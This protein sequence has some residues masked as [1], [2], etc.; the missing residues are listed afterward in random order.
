MKNL[1]ASVRAR[2]LAWSKERGIQFQYASMLY[3]QEGLLSRL[4]ASPFADKLILKGGFL[5]FTYAGSSSRTTRDIDFLGQGIPNDEE[6]MIDAIARIVSIEQE[7]GLVFDAASFAAE[8]ITEGADYHGVRV[9]LGCSLGSMRNRLQIDVGFGDALGSGPTR[10]PITGMLGR[11]AV[12]V[13][14]YPLAT[15]VA[16]KFE[17]MIA[18][19]S[20]NSRMKDLFDVALLLGNFELSDTSLKE[21]IQATFAQRRTELPLDWARVP[22][23]PGSRQARGA[24]QRRGLGY[25]IV[26]L[27]ALVAVIGIPIIAIP[28]KSEGTFRK[29]SAYRGVTGDEIKAK[30][31]KG[32]RDFRDLAD[33]SK[34][35][36]ILGGGIDTALGIGY[37]LYSGSYY[38]AFLV[39]TG[40]AYLLIDS[41]PEK[42]WKIYQ[43]EKQ[44]IARN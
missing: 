24:I 44:E 40:L 5:I 6:A 31:Q 34:R 2:L 39:G 7:D 30:A 27:G 18:L 12:E 35:D 43:E 36:R 9:V 29:Y 32:E 14:A 13:Y 3:M 8:Q 11:S 21:S 25:G 17:A 28:S 37:V 10:V 38:G 19:G 20:A 41:D 22:V 33:V 23:S 16:E 4:A 1:A 15:V 42:E 26:A